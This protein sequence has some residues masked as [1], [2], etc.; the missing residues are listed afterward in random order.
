M[1][2]YLLINSA[3]DIFPICQVTQL[4]EKLKKEHFPK[5]SPNKHIFSQTGHVQF[6]FNL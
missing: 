4:W 2:L 1:Y 3:T 5:L 6:Y